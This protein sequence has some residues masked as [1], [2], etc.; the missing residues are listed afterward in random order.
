MKKIM[1]ILG[2]WAPLTLLLSCSD[3][4]NVQPKAEIKLDVMFETEQGVKD[5][6]IGCYTLMSDDALYGAE[7]TCRFLD[8]LGQQY[9][10]L[11]ST[12]SRYDD[13]AHYIYTEDVAEGIINGI[14]SGQYN[15][16]ANINALIE[17]IENSREVLLPT[18]YAL[19]KAEAYSLRAFVYL[20]L[21]R[22]FTWGNLSE[23]KDKL[24]QLAIPYAKIYN[25]E[26][27][28]Q[29][30]LGN[31]LKYI[32][33]DLEVALGLFEA[34]DPISKTGTRPDDYISM[35]KDNFYVWRTS[36]MFR[37]NLKGAM[38]TRMRLN[39][40]EGNYGAAKEDANYLIKLGH[41]FVKS[42]DWEEDERDLTFSDEMLF[43]VETF[44]RFDKIVIP[45]FKL[46]L[47]DGTNMNLQ[48]LYLPKS[49]VEDL[50]EIK[51]SVGLSDWRYTRLW[52]KAENNYVF[53]KFWEYEKMVNTDRMPLIKYPEVYYTLCECL[54]REGDK[55]KVIEHLNFIRNKRNIPIELNIP[56]TLTEEE[57]RKELVKEICKEYIGEGQMF[58]YYK[59]IGAGSIPYGPPVS[60]NDNVYV[61]PM[62]QKEIDFGGRVDLVG[63]H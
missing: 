60:Y 63:N 38:A 35:D 16:I 39:L 19:S 6:L 8:V 13:A 45:S 57:T 4:L 11:G 9:A 23:R 15:V 2:C 10:L 25:K 34:Y 51:T 54:L 27:V 12:A 29:E 26:I 47:D 50:Y 7:L 61:L 52:D 42:M 20:D 55:N 49:R 40:W 14:W 28:P 36:R 17:G 44:E 5:A 59:R 32:H 58:Y 53:L 56:Y 33:E 41:G 62:P 18:F 31:V 22:L 24:E 3:W 30:T 1:L 21:V 43:G 37:M 48:A 46:T